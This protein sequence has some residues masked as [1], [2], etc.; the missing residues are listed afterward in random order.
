MTEAKRSRRGERNALTSPNARRVLWVVGVGL[1]CF[2][3]GYLIVGFIVFR[4]GNRPAVVTVPALREMPLTAARERLRQIGLEM[5]VGDSL[6]NPDV[7]GGAILA[8]S[9][10]A[11]REMP[12][13]SVVRVIVSAGR[14]RRAVPDVAAM[15]LTQAERM[16]TALGFTLAVRDSPAVVPAGRILRSEPAAGTQLAIP[17]T[18]RLVVSSGPPLAEVPD[19]IGIGEAEAR[20]RLQGA[21]FRVAEIVYEFRVDDPGIVVGQFP[22]PGDSLHLGRAV[23]LRVAI[24][25]WS[26]DPES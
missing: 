25:R 5:E 3:L 9:P 7:P 1:G 4:G 16:L 2:L 21:G 13:G 14:V 18:V 6:P 12:P 23:Q 17:S 19:V 26:D 24:D 10:L 11:G 8:Q 20:A 22:L 15:Q